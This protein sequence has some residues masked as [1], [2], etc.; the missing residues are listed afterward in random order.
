MKL[1]E[2]MSSLL[3]LSTSDDQSTD[4][5]IMWVRNFGSTEIFRLNDED[6]IEE[7]R[8][9]LTG[10]KEEVFINGKDLLKFD[11]VLIRN[12]QLPKPKIKTK[13]EHMEYIVVKD[14]I[15]HKLEKF[16][17]CIGSVTEDL[18]H[19]KLID[20]HFANKVG[21]KIPDSWVVTN[22][23]DFEHIP[24]DQNKDLLVK[25][26]KNY[27]IEKE[28]GREYIFDL[29][30]LFGYPDAIPTRF[31]PSLVQKRIPKIFE[32]RSFFL[33]DKFYSIAIF[34]QKNKNTQL[35]FKN[36]D[37]D[38]LNRMVPFQLPKVLE[39][40]LK[41]LF[42]EKRLKIGSVDLIY[43]IDRKFYFLEINPVGQFNWLSRLGNYQIE[44]ELASRLIA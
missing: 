29:Y 41:S 17:K 28:N 2:K 39:K 38:L 16:K 11:S 35:S 34:S 26:L 21:L 44:K 37:K 22:K 1:H 32:V 30:Q 4:E 36:I 7:L 27:Y 25:P 43:G 24:V 42:K 31:F 40:K 33:I 19:N 13:M 15:L 8:L 9:V 23:Q 20:F 5:L 10:N 6:S 18:N 12:G 14:F 3:I